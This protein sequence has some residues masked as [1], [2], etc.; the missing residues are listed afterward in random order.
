MMRYFEQASAASAATGHDDL[1][2]MAAGM[3]AASGRTMITN[4]SR[5]GFLKGAGL[6]LA[7]Q[8]LPAGA[9]HA[10]KA[11]P[12]GAEGMPHKTVTDPLVFVRIGSDGTVTLTAHR[13]EMGTGSRTSVPMVLA[14]EMEADW[15]KVRVVQAPGD[16]PRYGNQ[17]TDGSRS[18]RHFIQPMRQCG[19]SMRQMLEGAAAKQWGVPTDR[20][21]AVNHAV[22][23][24]DS[25]G[26]SGR[27]TG[28]KLGYG[29]LA[30]AAMAEPVPAFAELRFKNAADFRY[31]GKGEVQIVD[32]HDITTGKAVYGADVRLPGMKF[33]VVARPPVLGGKVKSFDATQAQ[34]VPGV[35][36]IIQLD[37]S[38]PPAKF[39]PLGGIA[40]VARST[41]AA[42]E[43]RKALQIEWDDGPHAVYDTEG[44][45]R[46]MS[47]TARKPAKVVRKQGDPD[48]AFAKAAKVVAAEY[49]QQ[50]MAHTPME[51]PA[52]IAN[53]RDGKAEVWAPVQS[54]YGARQDVAKTLGLEE[55]AVTVNQTLLGGGF[56]R[57]SKCDFVLEAALLSREVGAP[58]LVQWT[59][60]DDIR[61]GFYHTT[62]VERLEAALDEKG[63]VVGWRHRSVAPSISSTFAAD[64]G[65]QMALELGMGLV[66]LP[67]DIANITMENGKAL[68]HNRIGWF[69]AVSN[70][71]RAFAV[72]SFAGELAHELGRD[73]KEML[74]ELIG[75]P[76]QLD[77]AQAGM[78]ELWNY[79]EPYNEF[80]ID[81]GRLSKVVEMAAAGAG[82]GRQLP[83][84]EAF[85]IAAHRS[86]V[87]YVA[88]VVHV[89]VADDGSI[90]VPEVFT[91]IDCGFC[92]N[93]ERVRAQIEGAAVMGMTMALYSGLNYVKG[94]VEQSNFHDYQMARMNRYPENVHTA[95]VEHPFEVHATGVGEPG[96]PPFAPALAN[97]IFAATGK[98]LR[99]LPFG[100]KVV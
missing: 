75:P 55:S 32:L 24:L 16:E 48:A 76:R 20:V 80:P 49:Y 38:T 29:E 8:L 100:E 11:Y 61:H 84:G 31:I 60:E 42:L 73:Q 89:K 1:S 26:P 19:A 41:F 92:I 21:R 69:R 37:G 95:I 77:L 4:V 82:W 65:E 88:T 15:A 63:K 64:S 62:S 12:T 14:D 56:G 23:L 53:V 50:H 22:L 3:S 85:G 36:R 68:A 33:A 71:P 13:A 5:R 47:E 58:V 30:K 98:R 87:S 81:T 39:A 90:S 96:V 17:D 70:L 6:V 79:G 51:P 93:P 35:E 9:A 67:F 34:K 54:P 43:G 97:A 2:V 18:L 72:Q 91:A 28:R 83:K 46:E 94:R 25:A 7:V 44:Y 74:L 59:R 10:F 99:T 66:D 27:P 86:F 40:V 45:R 78:T 57:K 52:A